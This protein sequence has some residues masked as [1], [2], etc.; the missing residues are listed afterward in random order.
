[1]A[2][3]TY[4]DLFMSKLKIKIPVA[5]WKKYIQCFAI[6][7]MKRWNLFSPL[8]F[9]LVSCFVSWSLATMKPTEIWQLLMFWCLLF[10]PTPYPSTTMWI[11]QG[12]PIWGWYILHREVSV[13]PTV[14]A[15]ALGIDHSDTVGLL[16]HHRYQA[17][18]PSPKV[19][20]SEA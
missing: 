18:W 10:F 2:F 3:L 17:T 7:P 12:C 5:D 13:I 8:E 20:L 4:L 16:P 1:M 15:E 6:Y 9:G 11:S 19:T 14:R